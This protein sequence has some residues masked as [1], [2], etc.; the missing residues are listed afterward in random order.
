ML[1]ITVEIMRTIDGREMQKTT[2]TK[3]NKQREKGA[4]K[5]EAVVKW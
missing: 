5:T 1:I 4:R 3:K 2:T